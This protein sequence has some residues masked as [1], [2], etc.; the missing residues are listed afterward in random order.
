LPAAAERDDPTVLDDLEGPEDPELHGRTVLTAAP[1][2]SLFQA[3]YKAGTRTFRLNGRIRPREAEMMTTSTRRRGLRAV[4]SLSAL[5]VGAGGFGGTFAPTAVAT[6]PEATVTLRIG[7]NDGEDG[8][9]AVPINEFARQVE[10]LSGG[11]MRI[12]P[13]WN[14]GPPDTPTI[15]EYIAWDQFVARRVVSGEIDMG[16]IPARAW[17]TEGV[18]TLRALFAPFLVD[19]DALM[20]AIAADPELSTDLLAG[21]DGAGV[22]GLALLPESVRHVFS[23]GEPLTSPDDFA[24]TVIRAPYSATTYALF[25]ALG[26]VGTDLVGDAFAEGIADGSVAGAESAFARAAGL[27]GDQLTVATG[28]VTPFPNVNTLVVNGD[29]FDA[30][31]GDQLNVMHEA[32]GRTLD[33]ILAG[34]VGELTAAEEFC[35]AGGGIVLAGDDELAASTP[36]RNPS[37]KN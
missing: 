28:N 20:T 14:A 8:P 31:S 25:E 36:R 2:I 6:T 22:T 23:F 12:E 34:M 18:T 3:A 19:S 7:T 32:A 17:D 1:S 13:V 24:G 16:M 9:M 35:A 5:T 26:A 37:S 29:L 33:A 10:E 4:V 15:G 30:L 27:P 21:L 11:A